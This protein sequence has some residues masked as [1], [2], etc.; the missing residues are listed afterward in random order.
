MALTIYESTNRQ[1]EAGM[2]I[3]GASVKSTNQFYIGTNAIRDLKINDETR[4]ILAEDDETREWYIAFGNFP[5]GNPMRGRRKKGCIGRTFCQRQ[6]AAALI[7]RVKA[8]KS[9][10]FIIS[11]NPTEIDGVQWHRILTA[12]PIRK[13]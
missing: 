9:A 7:Q 10:T 13:N 5:N 8:V 12:S 11:K 3:L 2:W 6:A 4:V 1:G